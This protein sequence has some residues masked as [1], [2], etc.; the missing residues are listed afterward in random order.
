MQ[1]V[2]LKRFINDVISVYLQNDNFNLERYL[3]HLKPEFAQIITD[4]VMN[5]E[6]YVL[7]NW[8]GQN[9]FPKTKL[10]Q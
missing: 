1:L 9:I 5:N 3:M 8:E 10:E 6:K 7:H 4:I 2:C